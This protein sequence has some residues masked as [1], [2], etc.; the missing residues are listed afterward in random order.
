MSAAVALVFPTPDL[1]LQMD[2]RISL[3]FCRNS[4]SCIG[5]VGVVVRPAQ[6]H[7]ADQKYCNDCNTNAQREVY[8]EDVLL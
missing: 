1:L 3:L 5:C 6:L 8:A 7:I 2:P 4:L